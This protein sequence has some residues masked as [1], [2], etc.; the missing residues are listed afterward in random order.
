[1]LAFVLPLLL[2][3][4]PDEVEARKHFEAGRAL[5]AV[6]RFAEAYEEFQAGYLL[7]PRPL[8]HFNCAQ[9]LRRKG[10]TT[11]DATALRAARAR[12]ED[13]LRESAPHEPDRERAHEFIT[14]IDAWLSLAGS[15]APK[16]EPAKLEA[17]K[18][19]PGR[20]EPEKS[21][22]PIAGPALTA[23]APDPSPG[24]LARNP[25][26]LPVLAGV[27]IAAGVGAGLG[28]HAA[29]TGCGAA[30]IG[31]LDARSRGR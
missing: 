23:A 9:A 20:L 27:A 14:G 22:A 30:S 24:F 25:W 18:V 17:G 11:K 21:P 19:D 31:C 8:F 29:T 7:A 2:T 1:M 16:L 6:D 10:E 28:V 5:F 13:Y 3:G 15:D 4:A 12:Y 26:F